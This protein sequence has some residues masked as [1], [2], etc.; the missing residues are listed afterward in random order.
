[1]LHCNMMD[2]ETPSRAATNL[3]HASEL[4][5]PKAENARNIEVRRRVLSLVGPA[6]G[7]AG[8]R[9]RA[10]HACMQACLHIRD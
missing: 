10:V 7:I 8:G 6:R 1:M 5:T 4:R 2:V 9:G 3:R